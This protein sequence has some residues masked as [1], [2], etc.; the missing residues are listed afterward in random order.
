M[1]EDYQHKRVSLRA[2]TLVET[3]VAMVIIM[4]VFGLSMMVFLNKGGADTNTL[5]FRASVMGENIY[6]KTMAGVA[7]DD[8]ELKSAAL[9][10][11]RSVDLY[12][13]FPGLYVLT[14]NVFGRD[15]CLL[16]Q[17]K[18]LLKEWIDVD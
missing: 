7:V 2:S 8:D 9:V 5:R 17:K 12:Q 10:A 6:N 15:S 3:L 1:Q 4:T 18:E 11:D 16:F 13:D 14:I